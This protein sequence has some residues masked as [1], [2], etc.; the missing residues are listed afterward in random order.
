LSTKETKKKET[1]KRTFQKGPIFMPVYT[2][3]V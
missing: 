3:L 1:K 2:C